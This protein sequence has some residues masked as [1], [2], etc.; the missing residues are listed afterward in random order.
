MEWGGQGRDSS[1]TTASALRH[2][3]HIIILGSP[4]PCSSK[5]QSQ[6][7]RGGAGCSRGEPVPGGHGQMDSG[8][9]SPPG[10]HQWVAVAGGGPGVPGPGH[11]VVQQQVLLCHRHEDRPP[12]LPPSVQSRLEET[13][14]GTR[15]GRHPPLPGHPTPCNHGWADPKPIAPRYRA[16][17]SIHTKPYKVLPRLAILESHAMSSPQERLFLGAEPTAVS[18]QAADLGQ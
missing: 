7:T 9:P 16:L 3:M 14:R 2:P 17:G 8:P 4:P 18:R 1:A 6:G 5:R 10:S 13:V 15:G 12:L 11:A